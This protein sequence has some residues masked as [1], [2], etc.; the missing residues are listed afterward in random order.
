MV[1]MAQAGVEAARSAGQPD[2]S[3]GAMVD[4]RS[5]PTLVRP[6][7]TL[8]LPVWRDKI[9]SLVAAALAR[10]DASAARYTAE[11]LAM[12]AELARMLHMVHESDRMIAYIDLDALPNTEQEIAAAEAS[13]QS[14]QPTSG[15][16]P[17]AEVMA[18]SMRAERASALRDREA[19]VTDLLTLTA[20]AAPVGSPLPGEPPPS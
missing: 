20:Q 1:E 14:G 7:G 11:E 8:D 16:I 10:K 12:A 3:L 6:L 18:L 2:F 17:E 5:N 19:A 9:S 13:A 15:M 4:V